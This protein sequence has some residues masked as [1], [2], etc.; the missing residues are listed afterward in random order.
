MAEHLAE[1][2]GDRRAAATRPRGSRSCSPVARCPPADARKVPSSEAL[3]SE[4]AR[5][6]RCSL[7]SP[8]E[9]VLDDLG[10]GPPPPPQLPGSLLR[11][12]A[13]LE[14]ARS[15]SVPFD[16]GPATV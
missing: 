13:S 7:G 1:A 5:G 14:R 12:N 11:T 10:L 8:A 4:S 3:A 16:R 6:G 15:E 9:A 2:L